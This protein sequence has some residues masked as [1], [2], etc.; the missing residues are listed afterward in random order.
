M[1]FGFMEG[2]GLRSGVLG[3]CFSFG[4]LVWVF[5]LCGFLGFE[6]RAPVEK[7][8]K[9]VGAG[10]GSACE[11]GGSPLLAPSR[12]GCPATLLVAPSLAIAATCG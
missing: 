12:P 7:W 3:G 4:A 10:A 2:F 1:L 11:V 5:G 8:G 6:F 9:R